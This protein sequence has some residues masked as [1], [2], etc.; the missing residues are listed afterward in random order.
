MPLSD[1]DIERYARQIIVPR[2]GIDGQQK[3]LAARVLIEGE[4][5]GVRQ[6]RLYLQATGVTTTG[7]LPEK[8]DAEQLSCIVVAGIGAVGEKRL[9]LLAG[10]GIPV[11]WYSL[12]A[13]RLRTGICPP[14]EPQSASAPAA[15]AA[16]EPLLHEAAACD[17]AAAACA[18]ILG[19]EVDRDARDLE[20]W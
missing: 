8:L 3:L 9:R 20:L 13:G 4:E 10:S 15:P 16:C 11:V 19:I 2:I 18:L 6:A 5:A 1:S 17:A 12:E 14:A 7:S